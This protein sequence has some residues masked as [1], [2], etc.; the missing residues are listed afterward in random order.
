MEQSAKAGLLF[1][2]HDVEFFG[3][4]LG[5]V[6]HL[7]LLAV[8]IDTLEQVWFLGGLGVE[9]QGKRCVFLDFKRVLYRRELRFRG[10]LWR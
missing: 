3:A 2:R 8:K 10:R 9:G 6:F 4:V 1:E 7:H 5:G